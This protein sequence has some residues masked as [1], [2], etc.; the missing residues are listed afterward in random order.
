MGTNRV[1]VMM[2]GKSCIRVERPKQLESFGWA[3]HHGCGD[4][5]IEHHHGI[6]G[7]AFKELIQRKD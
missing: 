4:G 5:V 7:Q 1:E 3:M 6:V 2:A